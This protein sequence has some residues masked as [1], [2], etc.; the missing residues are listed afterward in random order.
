MAWKASSASAGV[1][2]D[3]AADAQDHRAVP[4]DQGLERGLV[5]PGQVALQ[6]GLVAGPVRPEGVA[7]QSLNEPE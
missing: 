2:E 5:P 4:A 6:Q 1:A 3:A 7:S